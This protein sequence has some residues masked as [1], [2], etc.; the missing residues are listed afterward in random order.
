[1]FSFVGT[2]LRAVL[3]E[4]MSSITSLEDISA[5]DASQLH[6]LMSIIT[7]KAPTLFDSDEP[8][9]STNA[10]TITSTDATQKAAAETGNNPV[11]MHQHVRKW[12]KFEEMLLLLGAN[13]QGI[14]D[15]WADGKGPLAAE[16]SASEVRQLI[17][18]LFQNTDRRAAVLARIK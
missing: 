16:C 8:T 13:L 15:R 9:D 2:L 7:S 3:V 1:M 11:L 6:S 18:A 17:R 5:E 12:A 4:I 10:D 14:S